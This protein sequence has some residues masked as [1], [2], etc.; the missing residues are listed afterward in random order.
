MTVGR[1]M[2]V[3][4]LEGRVVAHSA[5]HGEVDQVRAQA[6]LSRS[7]PAAVSAWQEAHGVTTTREPVRVPEN[8]ELGMAARLC[9]P[10]LHQD[11]RVGYLWI[12]EGPGPLSPQEQ[13]RAVRDAAAIAALLDDGGS[14]HTL[15]QLLTGEIGVRRAAG[16]LGEGPLRVL[17][18]RGDPDGPAR[19]G[20]RGAGQDAPAA[21]L[22]D[23]GPA[24]RAAAEPRR[25][26]DGAGGAA[27][28]QD[29]GGRRG[30]RAAPGAG[31]GRTGARG[32]A[33]RGQ[34]G[35]GR[36]G[37]AAGRPLAGPGRLPA[38]RR[39]GRRPARRRSAAARSTRCASIRRSSSPWRPTWTAGETPRRPPGCSTCTAPASITASPESSSW[40]AATSRTEPTG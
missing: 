40:P 30:Q 17:A 6:I 36:T 15:S 20:R 10:L 24:R 23:P 38:A 39:A 13:G 34:G 9:V 14:S 22:H 11:R 12:I 26:R 33:H 25:G 7:V 5:H 3:D 29:P 37:A 28:R 8:P 1:G 31:I 27:G 32:G 19:G 16:V 35:G 21:G 4:D 18:L 2:S